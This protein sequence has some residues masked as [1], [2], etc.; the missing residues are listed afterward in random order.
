MRILQETTSSGDFVFLPCG[1]G[2]FINNVVTFSRA[3]LSTFVN[4]GP[5]TAPGTFT[6]ANNLWYAHD[7]PDRSAPT[8]PASESSP[9]VGQDPRFAD[10]GT[11][12]FALAPGSPAV[13]RG[14][15]LPEAPAD[16]LGQCFARPPS[17]GAFEAQPVAPTHS[18]ADLMPDWWESHFGFDPLDSGDGATDRDGDGASNRE[19]YLAGTDPDD[20]HSVLRISACGRTADGFWVRFPTTTTRSYAAELTGILF[21]G[22]WSASSVLSGNGAVREIQ[23]PAGR[24]QPLGFVRVRAA[25]P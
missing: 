22:S 5:S 8:L 21:S 9:V 23:H 17:I 20:A 3:Q 12:D 19:E 2:R 7:Q 10:A 14:L 1:E 4:V 13:G 11:G 6:F 24:D 25:G 16:A 18:D 15:A